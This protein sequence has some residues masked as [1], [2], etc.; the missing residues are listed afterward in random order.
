MYSM[1]INMEDVSSL[2]CIQYIVYKFND[3]VHATYRSVINDPA[4][5]AKFNYKLTYTYYGCV[6]HSQHLTN[7]TTTSQGVHV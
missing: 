7:N 2:E 6:V 5:A 1:C 4:Y 3:S